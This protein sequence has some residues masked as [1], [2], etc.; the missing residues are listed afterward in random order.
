MKRKI[1][2]AV[3]ILFA[4]ALLFSG[5]N[6]QLPT[7][8]AK[9][10]YKVE[11]SKAIVTE[12]P[13][14]TTIKTISIPDE[15]EG[16]PV[17]DIADFA[18]CNLESAELIKIGKNVENIGVWAF[19]NNQNLKAFEVSEENKNFRSVDGVL[20]TKDMKTLLFYPAAKGESF[21]IPDSVEVLRTKCFYKCPNLKSLTLPSKLKRIEEKAFF[22]C[23]SLADIKIPDSLEYIGKDSFGYCTEL[24]ELTL[25]KGIKEIG[26]Y[27]FYNC[28]NLLKINMKCGKEDVLLG[29]SWY[30]TNNGLN[31]DKL[32]IIW[33]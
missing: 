16:S 30:P 31:I 21:V 19:E 4:F 14:K 33:E 22:R 8:N 25:P 17:T 13:N 11:N 20:Y 26:E 23:S 15:Y 32:E 7:E 27:A 1:I 18:G 3:C 5:C 9:I 28:S 10:K 12:L 6:G 2:S 29:K 24:K